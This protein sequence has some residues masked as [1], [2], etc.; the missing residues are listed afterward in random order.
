MDT[1]ILKKKI[2]LIYQHLF[3]EIEMKTKTTIGVNYKKREK[4]L[5]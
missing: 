5:I 2:Y 1:D 4:I 3:I